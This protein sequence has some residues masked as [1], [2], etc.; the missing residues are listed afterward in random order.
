MNQSSLI[1]IRT[2]SINREVLANFVKLKV[3]QNFVKLLRTSFPTFKAIV[4]MTVMQTDCA[5]IETEFLLCEILQLVGG[6]MFA[7][8]N[9]ANESE[10]FR[11]LI[12]S[13][14]IQKSPKL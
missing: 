6:P 12:Y 9:Q 2:K 8:S 7:F 5:Y 4:V 11:V 1:K 13:E 14:R 10:F 3:A